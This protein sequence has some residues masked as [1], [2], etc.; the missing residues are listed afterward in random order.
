V[1][2]DRFPG[3]RA[4]T[5][6]F[7]NTL[8]PVGGSGLQAV[9]EQ[10]IGT[11]A[12]QLEGID[13]RAFGTAWEEERE[14]QFAEDV[15]LG[16]EVDLD[17]RVIRVLARLRGMRPPARSTT[18]DDETA[19]SRST[20]AEVALAVDAYSLAFVELIPVPADV[21]PLL[22]RL[23]ERFSLAILSNWPLA[24]TIDA[25]AEAAGWRRSLRA[26]VVSQRV[27]TI[28]PDPLIFRVAEEALGSAGPAI[29]HVGDDWAAD[30]VGAKRAGWRAAYFRN[31]QAGSPLPSSTPDASVRPD[32]EIDTLVELEAALA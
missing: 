4:I 24:A 18:W 3:L 23:A 29:L 19:A 17:R 14:R 28:K 15:P 1:P 2:A 10:M 12:A 5:F 8:V 22:G 21:G 26:I 30:I 20:P 31:R 9:V 27:G 16:R 7:G 13:P 32:L 6:D 11:V 25:Y